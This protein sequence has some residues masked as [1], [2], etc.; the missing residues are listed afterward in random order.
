[1][2]RVTMDNITNEIV[3]IIVNEAENNIT[4]TVV[5]SSDSEEIIW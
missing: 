1:M 4:D 2:G 3:N 5:T